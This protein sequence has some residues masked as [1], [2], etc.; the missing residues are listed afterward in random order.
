MN[1]T[2]EHKIHHSTADQVKG[3]GIDSYWNKIPKSQQIPKIARATG[4]VKTRGIF[5]V[6]V[7]IYEHSSTYEWLKDRYEYST[8]C[9]FKPINKGSCI[10]QNRQ[11]TPPKGGN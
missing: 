3:R 6:H 10:G 11:Q 5:Q 1:S 4:Q 9:S 7:P 2:F 8:K